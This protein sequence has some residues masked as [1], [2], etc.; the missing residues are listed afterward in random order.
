MYLFSRSIGPLQCI[1]N[2]NYRVLICFTCHFQSGSLFF[3][4][5]GFLCLQVSSVSNFHPDTRGQKWSLISAHLFSCV[6]GREGHYKYHCR[7]WGVLAV[8]GPHWFCHSPRQR[9]SQVSTAQ[10]PGCSVRALS[11]MGPAFGAL[12]RSKLLR[13]LGAQQ[14]HRPRWAVCFV[15]IP[16]PSSSVNWVLSECTVPGGLCILFTSL[17]L[18]AWFP[19]GATRAQSQVCHV[20]LLGS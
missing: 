13:F 15:P 9:V 10:A 6:V 11:Q 16:D 1:V 2:L 18:A 3:V 7:V 5:F 17:V 12:P 8:C 19:R 20:S 4:Y 14:G